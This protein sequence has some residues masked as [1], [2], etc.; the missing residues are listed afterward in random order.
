MN[1]RQVEKIMKLYTRVPFLGVFSSD[2]DCLPSSRKGN[3]ARRNYPYC[4]IT[5][6]DPCHEKGTH[7]VVIYVVDKNT[8]EY[9][10]SFGL[11]PITKG[12]LNY[13]SVF[14]NVLYNVGQIQSNRSQLCGLY[15]V[16][17]CSMR[18]ETSFKNI[19]SCFDN[20]FKE[21][22]KVITYYFSNLLLEKEPYPWRKSQ[23]KTKSLFREF[24]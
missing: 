16:F 21:N 17:F 1:T 9:F 12:H 8:V 13:L 15:C 19:L 22:D 4:F 20:R 14:S 2:S 5:N 3:S 24:F 11:G 18:M 6:L 10:D 23:K 7:W